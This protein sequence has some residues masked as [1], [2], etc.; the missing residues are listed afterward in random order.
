MHTVRVHQ[1]VQAGAAAATCNPLLPF[2]FKQN[3]KKKHKNEA[4][5]QH[6]LV[7]RKSTERGREKPRRSNNPARTR[8]KV[9][10]AVLGVMSK[11]GERGHCKSRT[12]SVSLPPRSANPA[13]KRR[14]E[15]L[16]SRSHHTHTRLSVVVVVLAFSR[17]Q[18]NQLYTH[19]AMRHTH[20]HTWKQAPECPAG[21][22]SVPANR[23]PV[24]SLGEGELCVE[25]TNEKENSIWLQQKKRTANPKHSPATHANANAYVLVKKRENK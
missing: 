14:K 3:N 2:L 13:S 9:F 25:K 7:V 8:S 21:T 6:C 10:G 11:L 4:K 24:L 17:Q 23:E 15:R 12:A 1:P 5:K 16:V 18:L 20:T 19:L 22:G